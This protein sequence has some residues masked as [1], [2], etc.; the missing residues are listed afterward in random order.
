MSLHFSF[1][2]LVPCVSGIKIP[3]VAFVSCVSGMAY[4]SYPPGLKSQT[5]PQMEVYSLWH[6]C[7]SVVGMST[8]DQLGFHSDIHSVVFRTDSRTSLSYAVKIPPVAAPPDSYCFF[9]CPPLP[10]AKPF[11]ND[12]FRELRPR[13]EQL[14]A[15]PAK[16]NEFDGNQVLACE[17]L[18]HEARIK[19][20]VE[21]D[22][23]RRLRLIKRAEFMY[24]AGL[25]MVGHHTILVMLN[26]IERHPDEVYVVRIN[27]GV[28]M[29][30]Y[31]RRFISSS[32]AGLAICAMYSGNFARFGSFMSLTVGWDDIGGIFALSVIRVI[33]MLDDKFDMYLFLTRNVLMPYLVRTGRGAILDDELRLCIHPDMAD[34]TR[35]GV[36]ALVDRFGGPVPPEGTHVRARI[37]DGRVIEKLCIVC[38]A[39]GSDG[40]KLR[41]CAGCKSV[42]YC[43]KQCQVAHWPAHKPHCNRN[44]KALRSDDV[45]FI[46]SPLSGGV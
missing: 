35:N 18:G 25:R 38:D 5:S 31:L 20:S 40:V 21:V 28:D 16:T 12:V 15:I 13:L 42:Y 26:R 9:A 46:A 30:K 6:V 41:H 4:V 32:F 29:S 37:I 10:K 34:S 45:S 1:F 39:V 43:S 8:S 2:F 17:S 36:M 27:D 23:E 11:L 44:G 7:R 14:V 33:A 24:E 3:E 22:P 19:A